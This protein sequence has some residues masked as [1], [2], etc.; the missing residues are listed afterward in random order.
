MQSLSL[1]GIELP[2]LLT[3]TGQNNLFGQGSTKNG[4]CSFPIKVVFKICI[5]PGNAVL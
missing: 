1:S 5:Y 4:Y 2:N 3:I